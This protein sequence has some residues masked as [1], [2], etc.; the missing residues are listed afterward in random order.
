MSRFILTWLLLCWLTSTHAAP[1]STAFT[2]QGEL[3]NAGA[4]VLGTPNLQFRLFDDAV[5][6]AQIGATISAPSYPII[7]GLL[8][9][10]LDFGA[11]PFVGAQ[12][13]LEIAVEGVPLLPRQKISATPY[14]T[15]ALSVVDGAVNSASVTDGSLLAIDIDQDS[16][17]RRVVQSCDPGSSIRVIDAQGS[18]ACEPV[19]S[20]DISSVVAGAGLAGGSNSGSAALAVAVDGIVQSM[21]ADAAVG[22]AQIDSAQ[23]QARIA[24]NCAVGSSVR[25]IN[26]DGSVV[27]DAQPASAIAPRPVFSRA[28]LDL[29]GQVRDIS[30]TLGVDGLGLI[31]YYDTIGADLHVAHCVDPA[32]NAVSDSLID[33]AGD[34]GAFSSIAI[35]PNGLGAVSYYDRGNGDLK[36]AV[37]TNLLCST[38]TL[39][40]L[41]TGTASG[42][43]VGQ[44]TSL[45]ISS[46]GV[47]AISYYDV[48]RGDLKLVLCSSNIAP[49]CGSKTAWTV[50]GAA[51][52]VGS[53]SSLML[54]PES[55][56]TKFYIHYYDLSNGDLKLARCFDNN[57]SAAAIAVVDA[58]NDAGRTL[59]STI[60]SDGLPLT[61]YVSFNGANS[62]LRVAH[63]NATGCASATK[64]LLF[65]LATTISDIGVI[66][67]ADGVSMLAF[68][69]SGGGQ[70]MR[71]GGNDCS[72][73]SFIGTSN[74]N[75][76]LA[77]G[78][79]FGVT[80]GTDG[81]PIFATR[82]LGGS[83][84][85]NIL[86]CSDTL[87]LPYRRNR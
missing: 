35:M 15:S 29:P 86:H 48:S 67:G 34:V 21:I 9:I 49:Y 37:C 44:A 71:C 53:A 75:M 80:I 76:L 69:Y 56:V 63:C 43:D 61:A 4:P 12:R 51:A 2:Y 31:S 58:A 73:A 60:G 57:C 32:C 40:T 3:R 84:N 33:S 18:V 45:A 55:G 47:P 27:C 70:V 25:Q 64:S 8:T 22:L 74:G 79:P 11:A 82:R 1:Q 38:A 41:D 68:V 14:S 13:W 16:I 6:G 39:F 85:L 77:E 28:N 30:M 20:G 78:S 5:S 66:A 36:F 72:T 24:A 23:V 54:A 81:N 87:C 42:E 17:Q 52:D 83:G 46:A 62:E 10:E 59:A 7:D 50:D 19:G 26:A 65:A